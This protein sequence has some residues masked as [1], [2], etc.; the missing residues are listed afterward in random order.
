[1][2]L[3]DTESGWLN[4]VRVDPGSRSAVPTPHPVGPELVDRIELATRVVGGRSTTL[5]VNTTCPQESVARIPDRGRRCLVKPRATSYEVS[6]DGTRL[7]RPVP[8]PQG[9]GRGWLDGSGAAFVWTSVDLNSPT[10]MPLRFLYRGG[11]WEP[12]RTMEVSNLGG[13]GECAT[14]SDLWAL[15]G[16]NRTKDSKWAGQR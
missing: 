5:A 12:V 4:A 14:L 10:Y 1:M 13:A 7:S 9:S 6:S 11:S 2:C 8:L 15:R 16:E 3:G